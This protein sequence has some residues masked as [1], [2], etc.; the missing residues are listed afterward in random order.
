MAKKKRADKDNDKK[1]TKDTKVPE[2][3]DNVSTVRLSPDTIKGIFPPISGAYVADSKTF[4]NNIATVNIP[5]IAAS[6]IISPSTGY[7]YAP[8]INSGVLTVSPADLFK[9]SVGQDKLENEITEL[10][11]ENRQLAREIAT[12]TEAEEESVKE[13]EK[14]K[15]NVEELNK[16]QRLQHLLYRVNESARA[17][18][19]ES[20]DFRDMFQKTGHCNAVIMSVDIRRSTELMLKAREPQLY[21]DFIVGLCTDLTRIILNNYGIFD[22]FTGDGIL[23]FFPEF[24]S[25]QDSAYWAIKAADECHNCFSKHYQEKRKCFKSILMDVGLGIGIDYGESH[26][27]NIQDGL[28]VIGAPV[29]YACRMSGA[30]AG[31]TL[32]NQ[33]AYEITSQKFGEFVNFQESEIDM[34]HEGRT[35]AY[36][37]TLSKKTYDPKLP[38]WLELPAPSKS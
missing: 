15:K 21:A 28:T 38:D 8:T 9:V 34:K 20:A 4:F 1:K 12:K 27:V 19:I 32:L 36:I 25:G 35:L 5:S 23:S 29:V 30:E 18:L 2:A 11:K 37:A 22:K 13:I 3:V 6:S 31:R 24:Y 10:R 7:F 14:L 26:L 33:P 16:K 17:R